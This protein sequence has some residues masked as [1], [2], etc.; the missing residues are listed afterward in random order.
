VSQENVEIVR[1]FHEAFGEGDR[2]EWRRHFHPDVVWDITTSTM[3]EAKVYRGHEGVVE[4][5]R[6]WLGTWDDYRQDTLEVIDAGDA[7][8]TVFRQSGRG[9]SSG[10]ETERLFFGVYELADSVVT[11]FR[12]FESR[13]EALEAAGATETRR[14]S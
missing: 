9:R 8:V 12:L 7:V 3:P 2:V 5:F 10:V 11:R 13:E 4:F 1:S 14:P 6:D